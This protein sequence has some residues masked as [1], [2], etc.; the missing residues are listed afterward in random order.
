MLSAER[1]VE[2]LG[3]VIGREHGEVV[4]DFVEEMR[5]T[6]RRAETDVAD[7]SLRMVSV[8]VGRARGVRHGRESGL[9]GV[10]VPVEGS[11]DAQ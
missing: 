11:E 6:D 3:L 10:S 4:D 8:Y 7:V 2:R 9:K 1:V 5:L